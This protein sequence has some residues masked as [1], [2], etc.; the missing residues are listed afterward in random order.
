MKGKSGK[1]GK[2][3]AAA[4]PAPAAAAG[5]GAAKAEG[6][7]T[8]DAL[9]LRVGQIK[10]IRLHPNAE[11]LYLEDI[12][13]GEE[14]PRQVCCQPSPPLVPTPPYGLAG[15]SPPN[16]LSQCFLHCC[17]SLEGVLLSAVVFS[18]TLPAAA[19]TPSF[20]I[21]PSLP[22]TR[23]RRHFPLYPFPTRFLILLDPD[24]SSRPFSRP[25]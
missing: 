20:A 12:D 3:G 4:A 8:V 7:P 25:L 9:D 18:A 15:S 1:K 14:K 2:G 5:G 21:T 19:P 24:S 23:L 22:A 6:E 11:S 13:L 16:G 10:A 17:A